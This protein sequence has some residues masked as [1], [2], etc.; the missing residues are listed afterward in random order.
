MQLSVLNEL[1][2]NLVYGTI[3]QCSDLML[4]PLHTGVDGVSIPHNQFANE[5]DRYA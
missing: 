4:H 3:R 2:L 1:L 5:G